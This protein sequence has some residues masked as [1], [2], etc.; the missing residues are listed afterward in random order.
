MPNAIVTASTDGPRAGSAS[1]RRGRGRP[2]RRGRPPQLV[3]ADAQHRAGEIDADHA[4]G[5]R[6][7]RPRRDRQIGRAGAEIEHALACRSARAT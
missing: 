1:R 4:R 2:A 3:A 7:A 5:A 6:R